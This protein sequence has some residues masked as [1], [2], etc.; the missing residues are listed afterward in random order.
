MSFLTVIAKEIEGE[1][2]AHWPLTT[3][4]GTRT[5]SLIH[6]VLCRPPTESYSLKSLRWPGCHCPSSGSWQWRP[7]CSTLGLP[8]HLPHSPRG[9]FLKYMPS[10]APHCSWD[11]VRTF[12]SRSQGPWDLAPVA[13]PVSC[14]LTSSLLGLH[15]PTSFRSPMMPG[16]LTRTFARAVPSAW[17]CLSFL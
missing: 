5:S 12:C 13:S 3:H 7:P 9:S 4:R 15:L 6:H 1:Q 10:V 14:S 11:K 2:W 8:L 17:Y 16:P